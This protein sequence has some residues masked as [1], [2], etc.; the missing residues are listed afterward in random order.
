MEEINPME[1]FKSLF[2]P[3]DYE[4]IAKQQEIAAQGYFVKWLT[5][6]REL[7]RAYN[8]DDNTFEELIVEME[9]PHRKQAEQL[10]AAESVPRLVG[11][12]LRDAQSRKEQQALE[13]VPA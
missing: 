6:E 13:Q 10:F 5:S 2:G 11:A 1:L 4:K 3:P 8:I 12:L 9:A 7:G